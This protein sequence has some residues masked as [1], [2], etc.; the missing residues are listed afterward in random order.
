MKAVLTLGVGVLALIGAVTLASA[1]YTVS[2]YEQALVTRFGKI[3]GDTVTEAGLHFKVPFIDTVH[4]FDKRWLEWDGDPN[5][6]PTGDKKYIWVD[7]YARWRIADPVQFYKRLR[8]EQSAQSRLD[9]IIDGEIRNVIA[10]HELIEIVRT[11][12][13]TFELGDVADAVDIDPADFAVDKGRSKLR[14]IIVKKASEATPDYGI[15]LADVRIKRINYVDSVQQKVFDRMI[16]E[17]KRI[18]ERF[19]SE[20]QGRSAE[21]RGRIQK[22]LKE[23]E[24]E[25]YKQAEEIQGKADAEAAAIYAEAYSADT[26]LYEFLKT[27][28]TYKATVDD[29]TVLVL[30]TDSELLGYFETSRSR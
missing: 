10:N 30:S 12:S 15:E 21:I 29:R 17:R 25:A 11:S 4:H 8:D 13:R 18:A 22:E 23:I 6:I 19:R 7:T 28:E 20:G 3:H 26:D 24:S 16:S 9:D 2:E 27:L 14:E 5:Q 1:A